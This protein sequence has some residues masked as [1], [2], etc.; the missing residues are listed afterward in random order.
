MPTTQM[1]TDESLT[2]PCS[3]VSI[4]GETKINPPATQGRKRG[5]HTLKEW[6]KTGILVF[7][8]R[9]PWQLDAALGAKSCPGPE[10]V[11]FYHNAAYKG[12]HFHKLKVSYFYLYAQ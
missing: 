6:K 3:S 11:N 9:F 1:N 12:N 5:S 10:E 2:Y 7:L 8:V 4:R